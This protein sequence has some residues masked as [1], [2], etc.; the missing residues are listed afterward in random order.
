MDCLDQSGHWASL[1]AIILVA[2]PTEQVFLGGRKKARFS[3]GLQ[4]I[5]KAKFLRDF[6]SRYPLG[7]LP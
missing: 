4:T 2:Q 1:W 7:F 6:C 5:Q 3:V